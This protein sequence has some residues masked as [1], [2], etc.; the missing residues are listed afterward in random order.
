[1]KSIIIYGSSRDN[2]NTKKLILYIENKNDVHVLNL[3]DYHIEM[4]NYESEYIS[5]D[6]LLIIKKL[7]EYENIIFVTPIY[8]YSI[9]SQLK[10]FID[11]FTD[12]ITIEKKLGKKLKKINVFLISNGYS[13][14]KDPHFSN[15]LEK[16][17]K[18]MGMN[19]IGY[20]H[21][22]IKEGGIITKK[23][24]RRLNNLSFLYN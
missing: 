9:S 20:Q 18:Y 21:I 23:M 22:C 13:Y 7:I 24:K 17:C 14:F 5:N 3:A 1:M 10:V 19:F 4:Y 6:F 15:F 11:R 12:L 16:T 8:W 2:G